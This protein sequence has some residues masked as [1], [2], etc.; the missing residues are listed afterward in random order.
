ME[1]NVLMETKN[2]TTL[3]DL[4]LRTKIIF[5]KMVMPQAEN[6]RSISTVIVSNVDT[7]PMS[8]QIAKCTV[9][10]SFTPIYVIAA[11]RDSTAPVG[12]GAGESVRPM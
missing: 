3:F 9:K 12:P 6:L 7:V 4:G 11:Y 10:K 1:S 2:S 5:Q 8:Q